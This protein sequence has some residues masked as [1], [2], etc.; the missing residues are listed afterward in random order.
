MAVKHLCNPA[1]AALL[2]R[3]LTIQIGYLIA[4]PMRF[5][6]TPQRPTLPTFHT[7]SVPHCDYKKQPDYNAWLYF[8]TAMAGSSSEQVKLTCSR[9]GKPAPLMASATN[10]LRY[11]D[12][13]RQS[14]L[15]R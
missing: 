12:F 7:H 5:S 8:Y 6:D 9:D 2:I 10:L 1:A 13:H 15:L 3:A 14:R 11:P 4:E